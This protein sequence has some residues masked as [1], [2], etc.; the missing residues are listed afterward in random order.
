MGT[1]WSARLAV[2]GGFPL[3]PLRDAVQ[4]ELDR[5]VEQM[6]P[7][8]PGSDIS[9]FNRAPAGTWHPLLPDFFAVADCALTAAR[10]SDGA[11]DPTMGTVVDLWGFGPAPPRDAPPTPGAVVEA[12]ASTGW[13]RV[14]LDRRTRHL[15]QPG[16]V[17]LD[18]SAIA[19]G[20][21]VDLAADGIEAAG[22]PN[23]LIE[24]GGELRGAGTKPDGTP[25][26]VAL[27]RPPDAGWPLPD[28]TLIAL[29]GLS[30]A[31]S[32]DYRKFFSA[33]GRRYAHTIDPRTGYP[34]QDSLA[35]VTVVHETCMQADV[36]ATMLLVMGLE[37]G[38]AFATG[39]NIAALFVSRT[40]HG[41]HETLTPAMA[42]MLE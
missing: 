19:K 38:M 41:V 18:L 1:S 34:L 29:H 36:L 25:W 12:L 4:A 27:D 21:G 40:G 24:V 37:A 32:G 15:R 10:E 6:S 16:G 14:T 30:V 20:H 17:R 42:S 5:V 39:R 9:R 13:R 35:S 23:Y 26:W 33:D 31:T 2:P 22:I 8:E 3:E 28:E 7:W 11:Y